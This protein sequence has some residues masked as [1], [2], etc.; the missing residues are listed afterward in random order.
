M[1][2]SFVNLKKITD[3]YGV[4]EQKRI[5]QLF[6]HPLFFTGLIIKLFLIIAITPHI[7]EIWFLPFLSQPLDNNFLDP[8]TQFIDNGGD[9]LSFP[10]GIVMF[11]SYKFLTISELF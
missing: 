8:W 7:H 6:N 10:Y 9:A 2:F 3:S 11:R 5:E 1:I 4:K